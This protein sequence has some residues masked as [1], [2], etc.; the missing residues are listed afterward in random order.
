MSSALLSSS[1]GGNSASC[2]RPSLE[3]EQGM[4]VECIQNSLMGASSLQHSGKP[5]PSDTV[6]WLKALFPEQNVGQ[7]TKC[8]IIWFSPAVKM[9]ELPDP[10]L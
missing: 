6:C 5:N 9:A 7:D 1:T 10:D 2:A 8:I 3:Q 4:A